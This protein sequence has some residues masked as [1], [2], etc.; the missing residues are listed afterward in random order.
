PLAT[1]AVVGNPAIA[2]TS[3]EPRGET[4]R[5]VPLAFVETPDQGL[6]RAIEAAQAGQAVLYI[7]NSIREAISSF[8]SLPADISAELFHARFALCDRQAIQGRALTR[9][10]KHG[11]PEQRGG[12]LLIATQVVE[13]S[14]DL[15]FDLIVS[16]LAPVD[17]IIQ[18]AGRLWRHARQR[19]A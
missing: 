12:Q 16:D 13:Q 5:D 7:R 9:F 2:E 19:P 15:D 4:V 11:T 3:V 18:R 10:G 6:A 1:V 14:L 8:Q 17:L